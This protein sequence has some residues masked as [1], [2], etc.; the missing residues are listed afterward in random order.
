M[1]GL[2]T[3]P[4]T[5]RHT[6]YIKK[7]HTPPCTSKVTI[8]CKKE[9]AKTVHTCKCYVHTQQENKD[10]PTITDDMPA[11]VRIAPMTT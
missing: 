3:T 7:N 11:N 6:P 9:K 5:T 8:V 2:G 4:D 1:C 10:T